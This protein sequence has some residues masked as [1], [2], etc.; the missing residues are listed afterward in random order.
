MAGDD[1]PRA[2][3]P[4]IIGKPKCPGIMVGMD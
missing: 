1:T 3:F 4:S 2:T